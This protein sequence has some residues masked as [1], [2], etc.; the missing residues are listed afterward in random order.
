MI[1][2]E[3]FK[4]RLEDIGKDN[5]I[6]NKGILEIFEN[7]GTHHSDIAGYGPNDIQNVKVSW[8]LLDWK[9]QVIKRPKY[10]QTLKV[11][12]WART[13]GGEI[14]K[15]Y[16]Y[17][18]FE[19]YD[20]EKNLCVIGTSKWVLV[21]ITTGKITRIGNNVV[22]KYNFEDK[23]VFNVNE[24]DRIKAPEFFTNEIKYKVSR[25]DID[26]NGHMHN[27]YYLDLAYEVL[28]EEVYQKR[29][30]NNFRIQYKKEV[31][32]GDVIKCKYTFEDNQHIITIC[33]EDNAKIH[34]I[35][36]LQ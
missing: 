16:T 29:P 11:N 12:T 30:Y 22:D 28:P 27:L 35:V 31:K 4:I 2:S 33:S 15:S 6:K 26:I 18:D 25:R 8:V 23:N 19:M 7:I 36:I 32:I 17:R 3:E 24:L 10:G 13:I 9:V 1:F 14:K 34:A 5:Y 21:D 20:N